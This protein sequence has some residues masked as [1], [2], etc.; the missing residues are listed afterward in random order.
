MN[1]VFLIGRNTKI[2]ELRTT[3][4][5][6]SI[7]RFTLAV[8]R[9][10]KDET[11]FISCVAYGKTAELMSRYVDKGHRIGIAGH[12]QTGSYDKN[13]T[14]IYTTD[15]IVDEVEFLEPKENKFEDLPV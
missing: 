3:G 9:R 2:M 8:D 12:I 4:T 14:K 11:D 15:V 13:G 1:R 5:G 7:V 10:K 6:N